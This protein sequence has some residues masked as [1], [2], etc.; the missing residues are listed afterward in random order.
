MTRSQ[1]SVENQTAFRRLQT[2]IDTTYPAGRFVALDGGQ[3]IAD[4]ATF[5]ELTKVLAAAGQDSPE[6][7][8]VQAGGYYPKSVN[9]LSP[10][11]PR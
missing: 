2:T 9:L 6:V 5:E 10:M 11:F 4:A 7:L 1:R 8:V 3:I